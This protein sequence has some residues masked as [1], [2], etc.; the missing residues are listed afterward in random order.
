[1]ILHAYD[2][3]LSKSVNQASFKA[4]KEGLVNSGS[5]MMPCDFISD[6]GNFAV[7]N[8]EIDLG[9]H[10]TV[11]SEWR[12]YKWDGVAKSNLIS[13]MIDKKGNLFENKKK[14]TLNA[15]TKDLKKELQAQIDLAKSIGIK[16]TH[17]D[18]HE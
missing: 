3:G 18:S 10:L 7:N 6:V 16:P 15:S 1:M 9:L 12:D 14:F 17:I 4:L 8:P 5:V 11:T 2:L 13:S